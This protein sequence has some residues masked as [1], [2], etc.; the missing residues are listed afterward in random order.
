MQH[1]LTAAYP[2]FL[3]WCQEAKAEDVGGI[4]LVALA[5]MISTSTL[6]FSR[7]NRNH[8]RID[9]PYPPPR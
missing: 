1:V 5:A 4:A 9:L 7:M 2:R 3:P 6:A 8:A